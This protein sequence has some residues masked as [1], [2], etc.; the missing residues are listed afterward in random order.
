MFPNITHKAWP[1]ALLSLNS[2]VIL[3]AV[4]RTTIDR[5]DFFNMIPQVKFEKGFSLEFSLEFSSVSQVSSE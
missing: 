5:L 2:Y 3:L 1:A 4:S